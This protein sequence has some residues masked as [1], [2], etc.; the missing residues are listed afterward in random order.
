[1]PTIVPNSGYVEKVYFNTNLSVEEV[2]SLLSQ[3]TYNDYGILINYLVGSTDFSKSVIA[4][5]N[6]NDEGQY[7]QLAVNNNGENIIVFTSNKLDADNYGWKTNIDDFYINGTYEINSE[8]VTE[9]EGISFGNEN[10]KLI[11]LIS[12]TPFDEEEIV[13]LAPYLKKLNDTIREVKGTTEP[14][15]AQKVFAEI[16]NIGENTTATSDDIRTGK[17]AII[18]GGT[19][20]GT[21]PEYDGS[22]EGGAE[23]CGS[24]G[25]IEVSELPEVGEALENSVYQLN[26]KKMVYKPVPNN[27]TLSELYFNTSLSVD[28]VVAELSKLGLND[29]NQNYGLL[30]SK[31][32]SEKMVIITYN[33]VDHYW[34]IFD[35]S[36]NNNIFTSSELSNHGYVGWN[37]SILNDGVYDLGDTFTLIPISESSVIGSLNSSISKVVSNGKPKLEVYNKEYFMVATNLSSFDKYWKQIS[38]GFKT[39]DEL[40]KIGNYEYTYLSNEVSLWVKEEN[41]E[42]INFLDYLFEGIAYKVI[43]VK[44]LPSDNILI[45]SPTTAYIYYV[46]NDSFYVYGDVEDNGV[47]KWVNMVEM[48]LGISK[49]NGIVS[50]IEEI[51]TVGA[52]T[53]LNKHYYIYEKTKA[54][55][56]P[57][58]GTLSEIH[59][60][61][62]LTADE[63]KEIISTLEWTDL[64]LVGGNGYF[65]AIASDSTLTNGFSIIT[66]SLDSPTYIM[67]RY[68]HPIPDGGDPDEAILFYWGD[69]MAETEPVWAETAKT[70]TGL[71]ISLVS[72][73]YDGAILVGQQNDKLTNLVSING[74]FGVDKWV[75][76]SSNINEDSYLG[77]VY[78]EGSVYKG[79]VNNTPLYVRIYPNSVAMLINDETNSMVYFTQVFEHAKFTLETNGSMTKK[80]S[81]PCLLFM[82][83]NF[84]MTEF[85]GL[86]GLSIIQNP[87]PLMQCDF[88]LNGSAFKTK[89]VNVDV[90]AIKLISKELELQDN[91]TEWDTLIANNNIPTYFEP[92]FKVTIEVEDSIN[93]VQYSTDKGKTYEDLS[94]IATTTLHNCSE[95]KF[96]NNNS[97][98]N[99]HIMVNVNDSG[100]SVNAGQTSSNYVI[101]KDTTITI[102]N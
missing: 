90:D 9:V 51:T 37:T 31:E 52:Y 4:I 98:S 81:E 91:I 3:L 55:V 83:E 25:L 17:T 77:T 44:Y 21:M 88:K 58:E 86:F 47:L 16:K 63:V 64:S 43:I 39:V 50:S 66:D 59:F 89:S 5:T 41:G 93:Y 80:V 72:Q 82:G 18:N 62:E 23:L 87:I 12:I 10:N 14:F 65:Y 70:I 76:I 61:T 53:L 73:V 96:K 19:L 92:G 2:V 28:E 74:V 78:K 48:F 54:E 57:S 7:Y 15:N 13:E 22:F 11:N 20:E 45:F 94:A 75:K 46:L 60:N 56:V 102:S 85:Y 38:G 33:T 69:L 40:P 99:T 67:M 36:A 100:T 6:E 84:I 71:N 30:Y 8:V 35:I 49:P 95:I 68:E 34:M 27:G 24:G 29:D 79:T 42:P 1:M 101:L 26:E 32:P 97:D